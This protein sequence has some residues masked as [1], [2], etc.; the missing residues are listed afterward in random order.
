MKGTNNR[1]LSFNIF[2]SVSLGDCLYGLPVKG[3]TPHV[4]VVFFVD[5]DIRKKVS[6]V[7]S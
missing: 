1:W 2:N 4:T 3:P 5:T 7:E 6:C